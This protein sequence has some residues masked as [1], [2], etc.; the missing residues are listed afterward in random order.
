MSSWA[1]PPI[2]T[3]AP[4]QG[5]SS[6][7]R[8]RLTLAQERLIGRKMEKKKKYTKDERGVEWVGRREALFCGN[9]GIV[10]GLIEKAHWYVMTAVAVCPQPDTPY[11]SQN[12]LE[13]L[14]WKRLEKG[15]RVRTK[16]PGGDWTKRLSISLHHLRAAGGVSLEDADWSE[17]LWLCF[18]H[19]CRT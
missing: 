19:K 15:R 17:P 16:H 18:E 14:P 6:A 7:L 10:G 9:V 12:H 5:A 11:G 1:S 2:Q 4:L 3:T 8:A 13:S